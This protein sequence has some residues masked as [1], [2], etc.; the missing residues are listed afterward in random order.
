MAKVR[1]ATACRIVGLDRMKLNE[2]IAS[3]RF[4]SPPPTTKGSARLF[5]ERH[6]LRLYIYAHLLQLGL[7]PHDASSQ[8]FEAL[9]LG[10]GVF[11]DE[12]AI[13]ANRVSLVVSSLPC[14]L[15]RSYNPEDP[16]ADARWVDAEKAATE[17]GEAEIT[18]TLNLAAMRR[19]LSERLAIERDE[20]DVIDDE[21][22]G[23][24]TADDHASS[25]AA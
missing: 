2:D 17:M 23:T 16:F 11:P 18:I 8:S 12:V 21:E 4:V 7:K 19:T 1:T 5:D 9:R 22:L 6:L 10:Q 3:N 25:S 20:G 13:R 14:S 15:Q 24:G